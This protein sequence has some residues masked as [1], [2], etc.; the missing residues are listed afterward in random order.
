MSTS[1]LEDKY[2]DIFD[3][4]PEKPYEDVNKERAYESAID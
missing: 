3:L 4:A 2:K 1:N